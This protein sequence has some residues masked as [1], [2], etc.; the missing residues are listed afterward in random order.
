MAIGHHKLK[1]NLQFIA[2][3]LCVECCSLL[4]AKLA[5]RASNGAFSAFKVIALF[6][7]FWSHTVVFS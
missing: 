7:F 6:L 5:Q 4:K 1:Q 3:S 2:V